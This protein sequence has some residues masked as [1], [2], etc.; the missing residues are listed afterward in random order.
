M[1]PEF[2]LYRK[3]LMIRLL[4]D[5]FQKLCF[6]GEAGD[7]HFSKGQEAISVGVCAA[8]DKNDYMVTHHR[9]IAHSI[10][11]G[12][13]LKPLVAEILGKKSGVNN[14]MAGEM[15]ISYPPAKYM[16]SFQ[17]VGSLR[18]G[19]RGIGMGSQELPE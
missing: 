11:K 16:F 5:E 8:L 3:M 6:A 19:R 17:L 12:V 18:A 14:G 13:P 9:T 4:E 7:L 15:H 1:T 2:E 10:A